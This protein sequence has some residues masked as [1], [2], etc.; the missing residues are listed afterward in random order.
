MI[1]DDD[2]PVLQ[3]VKRD[4]ARQEAEAVK[5]GQE[6]ID[7]QV[8]EMFRAALLET[9]DPELLAITAWKIS[10]ETEAAYAGDVARFQKFCARFGV[11]ALPAAP[12][13]AAMFLD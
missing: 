10:K 1:V 9:Y 11:T 4:N 2:D 12:E 5:R 8:V 6:A 13:I 3:A 7:A